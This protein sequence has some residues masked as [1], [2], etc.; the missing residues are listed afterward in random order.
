MVGV[1]ARQAMRT[2]EMHFKSEVMLQNFGREI[3]VGVNMIAVF[4]LIFD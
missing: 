2:A 1:G 3:R 4:E